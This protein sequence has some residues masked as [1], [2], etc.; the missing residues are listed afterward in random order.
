MDLG[1]V[2]V[3]VISIKKE[4]NQQYESFR[5]ITKLLK[6]FLPVFTLIIGVK[7]CR[8]HLSFPAP[9]IMA[10][11]PE[12]F[13]PWVW[14]EQLCVYKILYWRLNQMRQVGTTVAA[15]AVPSLLPLSPNPMFPFFI[16]I[17]SWRAYGK[18]LLHIEL[19]IMLCH[20]EKCW[21]T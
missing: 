8:F 3:L 20:Q 7:E 14:H 4:M 21:K 12:E 17:L 10:G 15:H 2:N 19:G 5:L 18:R 13:L 6:T 1:F 16:F 9:G 11:D